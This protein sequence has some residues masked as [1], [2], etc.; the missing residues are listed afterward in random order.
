LI[1][2]LIA[3]IVPGYVYWGAPSLNTRTAARLPT[4]SGTTAVPSSTTSPAVPP[5]AAS[6]AAAPDPAAAVPEVFPRDGKAFLGISVTA[7]D[8]APATIERFTTAT[9]YRP[10]VVQFTRSWAGDWFDPAPFRQAASAG[11]LPVLSWEPWDASLQTKAARELGAQ[12]RFRLARITRGDFDAYIA[13][14]ANGVR[15]L[16]YRVAIR[17]AHEMNGFWYPWCEQSNGNRPG[18]YVDAYR[19]VRAVFAALDATNVIWVWSPNIGYQG[20]APIKPLYPGDDAVDWIGL[21]GYYGINDATYVTFGEMFNPTLAT[22]RGLTR[23]PIVLTEVAATDETGRKAD[24]AAD[25]FRALPA[26]P[27]IIGVVWF[28]A[29]KERDWQV[30]TSPATARVFAAAAADPRYDV[31]WT[32]GALPRTVVAAPA[33]SP[34]PRSTARPG[35]P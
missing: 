27:D 31:R 35:R 25:M 2:V 8:R 16:G 23:K 17:F 14:Y 9:R 34:A 15:A 6:S 20:S 12:P 26:S 1:V 29:I 5:P 11:A 21:S 7:A 13:S 33:A 19:H 4:P 18:D 24:W 32:P 3:L 28:E 30:S 22:L 10:R